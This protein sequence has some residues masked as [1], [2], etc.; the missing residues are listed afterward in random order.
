MHIII[1]DT[2]TEIFVSCAA[3]QDSCSFLLSATLTPF[4]LITL[5]AVAVYAI[6]GVVIYKQ[7]KTIEALR[8]KKAAPKTEISDAY[9]YASVSI[10]TSRYSQKQVGT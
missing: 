5:P 7:K 6:L 3:I 2:R 8:E 4:G 1:A 10:Q 9:E